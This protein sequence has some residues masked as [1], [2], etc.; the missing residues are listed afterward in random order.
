MSS[1]Q[2]VLPK[3]LQNQ[4]II[5]VHN[6]H[7]SLDDLLFAKSSGLNISWCL[8]PNANKYI[9]N[10]LPALEMFTGNECRVVLGTDSLASNH[11]LDILSE[12]RTLRDAFPQIAVDQLLRFATSNGARALQ[13]E[14]LLG[15]FEKGKRPGLLQIENDLSKVRRLL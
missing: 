2:T 9:S 14:Q 6:V 1:L 4:S 7:T 8:C 10:Q 3:F 11:S 5:L 15:S 13:M 12:I